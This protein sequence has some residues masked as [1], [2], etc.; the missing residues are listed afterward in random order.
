MATTVTFNGTLYSLPTTGETDWAALVSALL[1]SLATN[2]ATKTT[3]QTLTN[4]TLTA[5]VITASPSVG[6]ALLMFGSS[7]HPANTTSNYLRP[8]FVAAAADTTEISVR[9]PF[10]AKISNLYVQA[11]TGPTTQG[12]NIYVRKNGVDTLLTAFLAAA[13]TQALNNGNTFTVVAGDRLS[14]K[15]VGISGITVAAANLIVSMELTQA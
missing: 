2:A 8:G 5:P 4:K 7:S 6:P 9:V 3:A 11:T 1:S 14:V 13:A 10:D 12:V 15:V